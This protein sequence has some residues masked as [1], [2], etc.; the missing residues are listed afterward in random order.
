MPLDQKSEALPYPYGQTT[1]PSFQYYPYAPV[2]HGNGTE[3]SSGKTPNQFTQ[4]SEV[5]SPVLPPEMNK[6]AEAVQPARPIV[7]NI[8]GIPDVGFY[9]PPAH[10]QESDDDREKLTPFH[11]D[12]AG[13]NFNEKSIR[14][15]F[16]R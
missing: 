4:Q 6:K 14:L 11:D 2:Q 9:I 8:Q 7:E 13:F 3:V 12:I 5:Q 1:S 16:I 15:A 10:P